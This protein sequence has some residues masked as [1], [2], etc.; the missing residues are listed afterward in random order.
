M[1]RWRVETDPTTRGGIGLISIISDAA[2]TLDGTAEVDAALGTLGV[3]APVGTLRVV[4]L[5][6][7]DRGVVAR[8]T[9]MCAHLMPHAGPAV[10][11][12]LAVGIERRLGAPM[13]AG[14]S[15]HRASLRARYPEAEDEIEALMLDALARAASPLAIDLLLDQPRRWLALDV[16]T[17][18]WLEAAVPGDAGLAPALLARLIEP[19]LVVAFGPAN[20]GKSSLLNALAGRSVALVANEPGT[21]R[22]YVGVLLEVG[23]LVVRYADTPGLREGGGD[24]EVEARAAAMALA[25]MADLVVLCG[26]ATAA[27]Q[28]VPLRTRKDASVLRVCLRSDLG[29]PTWPQDVATSARTGAGLAECATAIRERLVAAAALADERPW[30]FWM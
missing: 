7:I 28:A 10:V 17:R 27:A 24:V 11:R 22:D 20:I 25:E 30:R 5:L 3:R 16:A 15:A 12:A 13:D 19:P 14:T 8:W 26:D 1:I 29:V 4:D 18:S 23:G 2:D 9:S 6:G 21:T